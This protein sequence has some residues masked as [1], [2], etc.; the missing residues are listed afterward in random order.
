MAE[1]TRQT[2]DG[3][4]LLVDAAHPYGVS[5]AF[6]ER[7]GGVSTGQYASLNLGDACGDD[8]QAVEK[9][10]MLALGALGAGDFARNLVVPKQVHGDEVVV[11][12]EEREAADVARRAREGC[13]AVMCTA[14]HVPVL[15]CFADCV[16]IILVAPGGFAVAHSGWRGTMA[17]IAAKAARTLARECGCA[18]SEVT[19][20]IGPHITGED[21]EVSAE[22]LQRFEAEFGPAVRSSERHLDLAAAI[23]AALADAGVPSGNV[24]DCG[25]STAS[26]TDRFFSYRA[27]H[28]ACGRHG[29]LACM[30]C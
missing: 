19:A 6:T 22:L 28:G 18:T 3:V 2:R 9:N 26:S 11:V 7:T 21:Y 17:R 24:L 16:P 27:E 13:D 10:R 20:Y 4:T 30:G 5:L 14:P 8:P 12:R 15:L 25:I 1:L 29:A 23:R